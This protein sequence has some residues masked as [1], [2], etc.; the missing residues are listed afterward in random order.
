MMQGGTSLLW[1]PVDR[2]G[3]L[4]KWRLSGPTD[5]FHNCFISCAA[6]YPYNVYKAVT[7]IIS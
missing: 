7:N 1:S 5:N 3:L 6:E 4:S 2:L